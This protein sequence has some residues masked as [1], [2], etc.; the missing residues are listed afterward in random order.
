MT[1][2]FVQDKE[3]SYKST[4]SKVYPLGPKDCKV[5]NKAFDKLNEQGRMS[6]SYQLTPFSL[7]CFVIWRC[8]LDR[9]Q[10]GR[11]VVD[12]RTLNK[13]TLPDTYPMLLQEIILA[14]ILG[15]SYISTIDAASFF[16]QWE[17]KKEHRHWPTVVLH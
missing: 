15:C 7:P 11:A 10:K 2:A 5:I 4:A 1:I 8:M 6:W 14:A 12:I 17:V 16:Y 9:S 3:K 13:I